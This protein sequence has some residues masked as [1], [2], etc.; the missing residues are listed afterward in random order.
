MKFSLIVLYR[1]NNLSI[2][3]AGKIRRMDQEKKR[4]LRGILFRHLDGIAICSSIAALHTKGITKYILSKKHFTF[5]KLLEEFETNAG[6]LNVA[7]RLMASQG[8]LIR[9]ILSDG[10]EI[11]FKLTDKGR[12]ILSMSPHYLIFSKIIPELIHMDQH[13]FNP[14]AYSVQ[15]KFQKLIQCWKSL[16]DK[17]HTENTTGWEV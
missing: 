6:Y 10:K 1:N 2:L 5:K 12:E 8:W 16:N 3:T 14:D 7:L 13:L 17:H 9:N 11:D 4:K 15:D